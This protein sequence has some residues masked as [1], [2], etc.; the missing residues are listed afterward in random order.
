MKLVI[1]HLIPAIII[2]FVIQIILH[3]IGHLIGGIV[4]GWKFLCIQIHNIVL[5]K[6]NKGLNL[7]L[8]KDKG[9]RCIM[10]PL[11]INQNAILYTMGGC[12][13]NL[14]SGI[15]SLILMIIVPLSPIIWLYTWCFLVFGIGMFVMNGTASMKEGM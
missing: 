6:T 2:C 7:K 4:S 10:Y 15:L 5:H 9:Y 1:I 8:V 14:L 11:S 13:I 3:E 12:I